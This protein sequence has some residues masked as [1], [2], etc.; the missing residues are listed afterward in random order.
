MPASHTPPLILASRSPRRRDLMALLGMPFQVREA[1][2][3]EENTRINPQ[4]PP[5]KVAEEL[6]LAKAQSVANQYPEA[7]VLGADTIVVLEGSVLG[8]PRDSQE[9]LQMLRAL[10]GRSH[11]VITGVALVRE[12]TGTRLLSHCATEVTMRHYSDK[13]M[14]AYVASGSPMD[15][16]GAYG[17]QDS[18]FRPVER[19]Y[20]CYQNVVGLPLCK[21]VEMLKAIGINGQKEVP[22]A[23]DSCPYCA[24][25]AHNSTA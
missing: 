12:A 10:K 18:P 3:A 15:K 21:L 1:P 7:I 13:E 22:E 5:E 6:A 17:I 25:L 4:W 8:K 16:A 23:P 11:S 24:G 20:G 19:V 14:K 2:G 9:A